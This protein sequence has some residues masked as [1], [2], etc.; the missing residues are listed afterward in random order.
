M[1]SYLYKLM[2]RH[3][4]GQNHIVSN[5]NMP[6]KGCAVRKDTMIANLTVMRDVRISLDQ[7]IAANHRLPFIF[8]TSVDGHTL[9]DRRIIADLSG[10]HL[11][12]KFQVLRNT[13][14]Y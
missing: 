1:R 12:R 8:C 4:S 10:S 5:G 7:A 6:S 3:Q 14:N 2:N 11:S 13:R 9:S